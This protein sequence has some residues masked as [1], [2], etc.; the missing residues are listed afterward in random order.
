MRNAGT[1]DQI[2]DIYERAA[3][4]VPNSEPSARLAFAL[5]EEERGRQ[6]EAREQYRTVLKFGTSLDSI[7]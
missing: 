4:F 1:V 7:L 6:E 5:V 3:R 2:A